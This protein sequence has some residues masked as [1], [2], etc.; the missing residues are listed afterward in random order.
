MSDTFAV[1][2]DRQ[3]HATVLAALRFY[4]EKGMGDP[5]NRSQMIH[6]L[7]TDADEVVSLD[8]AA[9]DALCERINGAPKVKVVYRKPHSKKRGR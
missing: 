9:I 3:E 6:H 8:A 1:K 5:A 2:L 7:A 4:Q